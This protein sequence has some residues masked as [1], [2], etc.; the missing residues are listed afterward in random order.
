MVLEDLVR[1]S[2]ELHRCRMLPLGVE[3]DGFCKWLHEQGYSRS[4]MRSHIAKV[5]QFNWYLRYQSGDHRATAHE[6]EGH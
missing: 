2:W 1:R 5:S 3:A 4:V 6:S